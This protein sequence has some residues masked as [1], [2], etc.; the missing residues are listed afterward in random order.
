MRRACVAISL[1]LFSG[2]QAQDRKPAPSA[3]AI[4]DHVLG[5]SHESVFD[6]PIPPKFKEE[7]SAPGEKP[8]LKRI[9]REFPP[10]IPHGIADFLPLTRASNMCVDCHGT[11][12]PRKAGEP[13]PI[14][15]SHYVDL[16]RAP[17][18]RGT[19][20]AGTRWVCTACHVP[21]TDAKPLVGN[22]YHP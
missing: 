14:P 16:R 1:L 9:N 6:V 15:A 12:G 21:Q 4:P 17:G 13:T 10:M 7:D 22:T 2:L 19:Q 5:L 18:I 8:V 11:A 20:L 3:Q